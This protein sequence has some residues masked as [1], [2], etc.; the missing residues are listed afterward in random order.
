MKGK[1]VTESAAVV[2]LPTTDGPIELHS[3]HVLFLDPANNKPLFYIPWSEVHSF[4]FYKNKLRIK[5]GAN[6]DR[7]YW[8]SFGERETGKFQAKAVKANHLKPTES[9]FRDKVR[10]QNLATKYVP[11]RPEN[12]CQLSDV[13]K[14]DAYQTNRFSEI[15]AGAECRSPAPP[16]VNKPNCS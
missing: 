11:G 7:Q 5:F 12:T 8:T 13:C 9:S 15:I 2:L 4:M 16:L 10:F 3:T 14:Y 6:K 1:S